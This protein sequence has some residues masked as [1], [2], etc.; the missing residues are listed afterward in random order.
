MRVEALTYKTVAT[1]HSL[2]V[3]ELPTA[4]KICQALALSKSMLKPEVRR[5]AALLDLGVLKWVRVFLRHKGFDLRWLSRCFRRVRWTHHFV[6][7][8]ILLGV[9][10][11]LVPDFDTLLHVTYIYTHMYI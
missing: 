10:A 5:Q 7:S 3:V 9:K 6:T 2:G 1:S 11:K 4:P 8:P